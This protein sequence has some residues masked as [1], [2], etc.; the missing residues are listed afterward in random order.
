MLSEDDTDAEAHWGAVISRYGIIYAEDPATGKRVP[1]FHRL[2]LESILSD[3]DYKAAVEY[4]PDNKSRRI[5]QKEGARIAEMQK[6]LLAI[7]RNE[8]PCDVFICYKETDENGRRTPDSLSARN[9]CNGLTEAAGL[10]AK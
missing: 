3:E 8:K 2:R 6:T 1:A 5:Y 9:V 10:T 7:A 4:A